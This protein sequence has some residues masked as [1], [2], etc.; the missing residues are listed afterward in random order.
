VAELHT[1]DTNS[2]RD[3]A[4]AQSRVGD[5]L[6]SLGRLRE[7]QEAYGKYLEIFR[8]LAEQDAANIGWQWEL[9]LAHG[10]IGEG[11]Q[12]LGQLE[13]A[14]AAYA[15]HLAILRGLANNDPTI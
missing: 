6:Q 12:A 11:L 8:R 13:R 15:E 5:V 7:A 2:Q 4:I 9:A 14:Q 1:D 10:K 3:L